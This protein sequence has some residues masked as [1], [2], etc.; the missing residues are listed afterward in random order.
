VR[1]FARVA[2][3]GLV[4]VILAI[5][6]SVAIIESNAPDRA[7]EAKIGNRDFRQ[8]PVVEYGQR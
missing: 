4:G 2:I 3:S 1:T 6:A 8:L 5:L 7:A